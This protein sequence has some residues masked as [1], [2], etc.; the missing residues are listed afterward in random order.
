ML[1]PVLIFLGAGTGGLLRWWLTIVIE[2]RFGAA[3]P[4]GTLA[5]NILGC[6]A[7]GFIAAWLVTSARFALDLR[8]VLLIGFLGGFTTFSAFGRESFQLITAGQWSRAALYIT[9]SVLLSI[10]A[11]FL[12]AS[13]AH[14]L[15]G[16]GTISVPR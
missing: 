10:A 11:V 14:R 16:P 8:E 3:F 9:L 12:G 1:K 6:F 2:S 7:A 4:Y 13:A 15:A 5:V